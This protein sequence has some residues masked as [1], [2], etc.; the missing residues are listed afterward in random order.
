MY[1][2]TPIKLTELKRRGGDPDCLAYLL[3]WAALQLRNKL[4]ATDSAI[5]ILE[6]RASTLRPEQI[7]A[8]AEL[9]AHW[10]SQETRNQCA[11]SAAG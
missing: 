11:D 7:V 9:I 2:K 5:A 4:G 6:G 3:A 1:P 8:G 10:K